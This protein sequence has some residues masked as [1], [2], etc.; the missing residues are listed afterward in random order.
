MTNIR[1]FKSKVVAFNKGLNV[2]CG[3][4]ESG[5]STIVDCLANML[6]AKTDSAAGLSML[7]WGADTANAELTFMSSDAMEYTLIKDF[8]KNGGARLTKDGAVLTENVSRIQKMI[9]SETGVND[10]RVFR[11]IFC[12]NQGEMLRVSGESIKTKQKIIGLISGSSQRFTSQ[13]ALSVL[14]DEI[15]RIG[16]MSR[17]PDVNL[18]K[19]VIGCLEEEKRALTDNLHCVEELDATKRKLDEINT[20]EL[21][22]KEE[23]NNYEQILDGNRQHNALNDSKQEEAVKRLELRRKLNQIMRVND[24]IKENKEKTGRLIYRLNPVFLVLGII[25]FISGSMMFLSEKMLPGAAGWASG[26]LLFLVFMLSPKRKLKQK[27]EILFAKLEALA[28]EDGGRKIEEKEQELLQKVYNIEKNMEGLGKYKL[29]PAQLL[30]HE[31]TLKKLS[32]EYE[33]LLDVQKSLE[34]DE[35]AFR[36][37]VASDRAETVDGIGWVEEKIESSGKRLES[38]RI[39][40]DFLEKAD[41]ETNRVLM[42]ELK[43]ETESIMNNITGGKYNRVEIDKKEFDV[44]AFSVEKGEFVDSKELSAGTLDQ[45]YFSLRLVLARIIAHHK[46]VPL[47]LDDPFVYFD[48]QRKEN[49]M[50]LLSKL[51]EDYQILVFNCSDMFQAAGK[52]IRI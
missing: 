24:R 13:H 45:L 28:G 41:S 30:E 34:A 23:I 40:I 52:N 39:A 7:G 49:A 22:K 29:K 47:I 4:N 15:K 19:G 1:R 6:F 9:L 2:I 5:K 46:H 14:E 8:G 12:L 37:T 17:S 27:E 51:S 11:N 16:G 35:K 44:K 43:T 48:N 21:R 50:G 31:K 10:E 20:R 25:L 38:C 36:S 33:G 26:V 3:P 32:I 42:P 18:Q